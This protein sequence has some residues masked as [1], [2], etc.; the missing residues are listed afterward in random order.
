[1]IGAGAECLKHKKV[2]FLGVQS[3]ILHQALQIFL[4]VQ[5]NTHSL[6]AIGLVSCSMD[7]VEININSPNKDGY[8][9]CM[10]PSLREDWAGRPPFPNQGQ[11]HGIILNIISPYTTLVT[12]IS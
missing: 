6:P 12:P 1:M 5:A 2:T 9:F 3:K 4:S 7:E 10:A 8:N 11:G